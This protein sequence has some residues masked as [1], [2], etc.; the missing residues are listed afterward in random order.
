MLPMGGKSSILSVS[1]EVTKDNDL[2]VLAC[3]ATV[4]TESF[5]TNVY[6]STFSVNTENVEVKFGQA[7]TLTCSVDNG[8]VGAVKI[9]W[10]EDQDFEI[11]GTQKEVTQVDNFV[12]TISELVLKEAK[13]DTLYICQVSGT[14]TITSSFDVELVVNDILLSP[15]GQIR[16]FVGTLVN[17]VCSCQ[18][19]LFWDGSFSWQLNAHICSSVSCKNKKDTAISSSLSI[20]ATEGTAGNWTCTFTKFSLGK[21]RKIESSP[22]QL[23]VIELTGTQTPTAMWGREGDEKD[24]ICRVPVGLNY[25]HLSDIEWTLNG[26]LI[27]EGVTEPTQTWFTLGEKTQSDTELVWTIT[28][29][30]SAFTEGDLV[31]RPLYSTGE[32]LQIP[33]SRIHLMTLTSDKNIA[34]VSPN[35]GKKITFIT[36]AEEKP[37]TTEVILSSGAY[38]NRSFE[39]L[40][41]VNGGVIYKEVIAFFKDQAQ[42]IKNK[43]DLGVQEFQYTYMIN[44]NRSNEMTLTGKVIVVGETFVDKSPIWAV[45]GERVTLTVHFTALDLSEPRVVWERQNG[46][47]WTNIMSSMSERIL[48]SALD[49]K[50]AMFSTLLMDRMNKPLTAVYRAK[51]EISENV[52]ISD[53][54]TVKSI[55][56][57]LHEVAPIFEGENFFLILTI[58]SGPSELSQITLVH[59]ESGK[60]FPVEI[61]DH[62][63]SYPLDISKA[64]TKVYSCD[65]GYYSFKVVYKAGLKLQSN[66][67]KVEVK[68]RCRPLTAPPNTILSEVNDP[69]SIN[70]KVTVKCKQEN[71]YVYMDEKSTEVWCDTSTGTYTEDQLTPCVRAFS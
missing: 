11:Q 6:L 50:N 10:F 71:E 35:G 63:F 13:K 56:T 15:Q 1:G 61:P 48:L 9:R 17:M 67:V 43:S 45:F 22:L 32:V 58:Y 37:R 65:Q 42:K 60:E 2:I 18:S 47:T 23:T 46:F 7:A 40:K 27:S 31:C 70:Y 44:H 62:A 53:L 54:L 5:D 30:Y 66:K 21:S 68:R 8:H 20:A 69:S 26:Y 33:R 28:L 39:E 14:D 24:V 16:A 57:S 4:G 51:I 38:F 59:E 29:R 64:L 12:T 36:R 19:D 52:E 34:N 3:N 49:E 55:N 25:S 41:A